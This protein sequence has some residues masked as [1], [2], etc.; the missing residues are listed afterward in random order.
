M[1]AEEARTAEDGDQLVEVALQNHRRAALDAL[2]ERQKTIQ[3]PKLTHDTE[4][5]SC[6]NSFRENVRYLQ[7]RYAFYLTEKAD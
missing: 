6:N 4:I 5:I 3:Q 1:A 2:L 7:K